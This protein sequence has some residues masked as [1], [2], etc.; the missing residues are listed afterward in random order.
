MAYTPVISIKLADDELR[1]FE[2]M[3]GALGREKARVGLSR[4]VNRVTRTV[5]TRVIRAIARQSSIP[6]AIVRRS[7][8][9]KLSSQ[10]GDGPIEGIV[11]AQGDPVPL[12]HFSA[13]QFSFGVKARIWGKWQRF[14]GTF[15]WAG[16]F[17]SGKA[18]RNGHVFQRVTA[19]SLPI[20]RQDGPAVPDELVRDKSLEAFEETVRTMLPARAMHE[21]SRLLNA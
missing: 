10:K 14:P 3:I 2:N 1:R 15:I 19:S 11:S 16:T 7:I 18:V 9:T 4:A 12:K 13:K 17:R 5:Q 8:Y 21:L 6:T 20:V